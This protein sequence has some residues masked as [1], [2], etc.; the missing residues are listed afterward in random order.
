MNYSRSWKIGDKEDKEEFLPCLPPPPHPPSPRS[1][2]PHFLTSQ[3]HYEA[4]VNRAK[5]YI[6]AGDIFQANI[7]LRFQASTTACGW[8]IYQALQKINPSHEC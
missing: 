7:S 5:K 2:S 8:E 3:E 6:Q 1:S 4:A